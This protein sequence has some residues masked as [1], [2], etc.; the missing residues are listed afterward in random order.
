[1]TLAK[2]SA[3]FAFTIVLAACSETKT[4]RFQADFDS[5]P[6][7][8]L[9]PEVVRLAKECRQTPETEQKLSSACVQQTLGNELA[10]SRGWCW[11]PYL[12]ANTDKSWMR[13]DEDATMGLDLSVPWFGLNTSGTCQE[14]HPQDAVESVLAHGGQWNIK[15]SL[16]PTGFLDIAN[17]LEGGEIVSVRL[18]PSCGDA[19]M[20]YVE[21][22]DNA[23]GATV[24][25]PLGWSLTETGNFF[26]F[27]VKDCAAYSFGRGMG[28]NQR[29]VETAKSPIRLSDGFV[30][31]QEGGPIQYD[32]QPGRGLAGVTCSTNQATAAAFTEKMIAAFGAGTKGVGT[33][34]K[35]VSGA[36][37][38]S[39][40][41]DVVLGQSLFR[42]SVTVAVE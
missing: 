24:S 41:S 5:M 19:R 4:E 42:V 38:I 33:D 2:L 35:W 6:D 11:G 39:A 36:Y 37:S 8:K 28:C 9:L 32:F 25:A 1:M 20:V 34:R 22:A 3:V 7:D 16:T 27:T 18:F 23:D 15:T 40:T 30:P 29:Y 12:A 14:A 26:G 31:C 10:V 13:C 17:R 21:P